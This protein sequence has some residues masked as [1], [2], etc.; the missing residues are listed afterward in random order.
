ML[1]ALRMIKGEF[2]AFSERIESEIEDID[3]PRR[4]KEEERRAGVTAKRELG[5]K[6][7]EI[8]VAQEFADTQ[9]EEERK[10][11]TEALKNIPEDVLSPEMKNLIAAQLPAS[12]TSAVLRDRSVDP[13][14]KER[15][16]GVDEFGNEIKETVQYF[17]N[18]KGEWS[19]KPIE[20][21][22]ELVAEEAQATTEKTEQAAA[23]LK[24]KKENIQGF[25]SE[26][27]PGDTQAVL[28]ILKEIDKR[29]PGVLEGDISPE[30]AAEITNHIKKS[31]EPAKGK[32]GISKATKKFTERFK[33]I[34]GIERLFESRKKPPGKERS[35]VE[36]E[37]REAERRA[38]KAALRGSEKP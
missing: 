26:V 28:N 14:I 21:A 3:A 17:I 13:V 22:A 24:K 8:K 36:K 19:F 20:K 35:L 25:L 29:N 9:K 37:K 38:E 18:D 2:P 12:V 33:E 30:D 16:T 15:V 7:E 10:A 11:I 4:F 32:K 34:A 31:L 23:T 5:E 1:D 27:E 6:K